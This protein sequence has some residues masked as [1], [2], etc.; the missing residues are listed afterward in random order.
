MCI[1]PVWGNPADDTLPLMPTTVVCTI[2]AS[3]GAAIRDALAHG[4]VDVTLLVE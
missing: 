2:S 1:S 4:P 3:D